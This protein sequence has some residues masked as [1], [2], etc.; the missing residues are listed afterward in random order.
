M[1]EEFKK[2]VQ[3]KITEVNEHFGSVHSCFGSMIT[4]K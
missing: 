4:P 3:N 1:N 2:A